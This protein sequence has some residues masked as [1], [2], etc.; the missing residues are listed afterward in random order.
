MKKPI[1]NP[2]TQNVDP[3]Y[4]EKVLSSYGLGMDRGNRKSRTMLIGGISE[5]VRAEH[6]L[7]EKETG[8]V[9]PS[10]HGPNE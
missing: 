3:G 6:S 5:L 7:Y 4:W 9:K 2:D 1:E 8:A 10:G